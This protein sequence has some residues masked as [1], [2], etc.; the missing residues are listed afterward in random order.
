MTGSTWWLSNEAITVEVQT[1]KGIITSA[2]PAARRFVGR[3]LDDLA[4]W[5]NKTRKLEV[6]KLA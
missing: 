6:K 4:Y 3:P 2:P 1:S 5:M